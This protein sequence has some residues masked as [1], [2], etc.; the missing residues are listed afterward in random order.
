MQVYGGWCVELVDLLDHSGPPTPYVE[1]GSWQESV[2]P[3]DLGLEAREDVEARLPLY[4]AVVVDTGFGAHRLLHGRNGEWDL[5][6][7]G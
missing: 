7:L 5:E 1:C 2:V 4:D 3:E 6:R